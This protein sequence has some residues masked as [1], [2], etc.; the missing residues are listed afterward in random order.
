MDQPITAAIYARISQD[1][2]VSGKYADLNVDDQV[3]RCLKYVEA[4]DWIPGPT[5]RDDSISATSGAERPAFEQ[6]LA[7]SP[8]VVVADKQDRLTRGFEDTLRIKAAGITGYFLDGGKLSFTTADEE[9]FTHIRTAMDAAEGRKKAERQKAAN[10]RYAKAG[11]YRGSIR[12]FGQTLQ[13]K[14]VEEEAKA[15][16]S[17]A[18]ALATGSTNFYEVAKKWN[19]AGLLP[20]VTGKQG[21]REWTS[22]TVRNYFTRPRLIGKQDY[23]GTLYDLADWRPLLEEETYGHIQTLINSKRTGKRGVS[24]G[25]GDTHLLTGIVKCQC[26]R[27]MNVGY[28]GAKGSPRVYRCP[29]TGHQSVAAEPLERVV[30]LH[31][32]DL[33]SRHDEADTGAEEAT[34]LIGE[35]LAAK[36]NAQSQHATWIDE[37]VAARLS[38]A[39]I[40]KA[41]EGQAE[42]LSSLDAQI[43]QHREALGVSLLAVTHKSLRETEL[44]GWNAAPMTQRRE[45]LLSLFNAVLV[46]RGRQGQR[47][48]RQRVSYDHT[49][50]GERLWTRW[51]NDMDPGQ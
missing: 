46:A 1:K 43:M 30:I 9:L 13:G 38:P 5:Y 27:G 16:R 23:K 29:T 45:V 49:P 26:G 48:D 21:G 10:L 3:E 25:R 40:A 41:E 39:V 37:A 33:V 8:V 17:A 36:R 4:Q 22:G 47:F 18:K 50:L 24:A 42:R 7:D 12:P 35:L 28:R 15:V 51:A 34:K 32:L 44:T 20:P 11:K 2:H 14:W 19:E 31:A 6:M